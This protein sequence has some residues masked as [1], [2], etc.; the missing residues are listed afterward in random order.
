MSFSGLVRPLASAPAIVFQ[1]NTSAIHR[2]L[3][4]GHKSLETNEFARQTGLPLEAA[5]N[6]SISL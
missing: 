6:G 2:I 3:E 5:H 4:T 1:G